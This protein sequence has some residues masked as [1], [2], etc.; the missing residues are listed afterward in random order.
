ME[1]DG[2][3]DDREDDEESQPQD[4]ERERAMFHKDEIL[5]DNQV[6]Q[7]IFHNK[8]L[9]H[10]VIGRDPYSM[11]GIDG[12][13]S[14]MRVDQTRKMRGFGRIGATVGLAE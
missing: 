11:C 7:C 5:L 3:E 6:S 9:L 8:G 10:G 1:K 2:T 14:G 13:Q 12:G 4:R